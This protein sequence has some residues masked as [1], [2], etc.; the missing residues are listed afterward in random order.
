MSRLFSSTPRAWIGALAGKFLQARQSVRITADEQQERSS[1]RVRLG[2]TLL[3]LLQRALVN[4]QLPGE[5]GARAV[6]ALA[7]VFDELRVDLKSFRGVNL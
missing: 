2:T 5:H 6:Q 4:P 1:L 3:P 7:S